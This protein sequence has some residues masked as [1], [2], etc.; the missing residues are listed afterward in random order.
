MQSS[1]FSACLLAD[2][3]ELNLPSNITISF[4]EGREKLMHFQITIRPDEGIYRC[5]Q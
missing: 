4:P 3:S 1:S 2:M 5:V